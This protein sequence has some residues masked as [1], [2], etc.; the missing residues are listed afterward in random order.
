MNAQI[1][2]VDDEQ[3]FRAALRTILKSEG[4]S[5]LEAQQGEIAMN[6]VR[7]HPIDLAL[8]DLFMPE[9]DGLETILQMRRHAPQVKIIAIS[10]GGQYGL[11][12]VLQAARL[13]GADRILTKPFDRQAL[14]TTIRTLLAGD[15]S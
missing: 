4:Y 15:V 3:S 8:I 6:L 2:I 14:L 13:M 5:V 11:T 7:K 12:D 9:Q 1:L 10:G